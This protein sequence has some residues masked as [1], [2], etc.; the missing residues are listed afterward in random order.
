MKR[1]LLR[2]A[3]VLTG[4]LVLVAAASFAP[5]GM[6]D[7]DSFNV[8][9]VQV[10]GVH[11]LS[12]DAAVRAS[13]ITTVSNIFEDPSA[14]LAALK[15]HPLVLDARI[16]RRVPNTLVLHIT[17]THPVAFARTPELRPIDH[18]GRVLPADAA[19]EDMD[20]PVLT[21][22]TRVS[23]T[24][25]AADPETQRI[26]AFLGLVERSEPGLLGW[27]SEAG[28]YGDAVRLILRNATDAEVLVPAEPTAERLRELNIMLSELAMA[29]GSETELS[30]VRRIDVRFHD[31]I[32]VALHGRKN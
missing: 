4:L 32:V 13:G 19:D 20:L 9:R 10:T 5:L 27:I 11:L 3:A 2:A 29:H 15:R 1:S 31:Q 21:V 28:V 18:R 26:A 16:E 6:R 30:R 12:P 17:E 23:A 25:S 22:E 24:G 14:W 8:Q 7:M